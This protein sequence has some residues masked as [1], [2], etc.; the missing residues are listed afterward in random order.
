MLTP[1]EEGIHLLTL[2]RFGEAQIKG[3]RRT[4]VDREKVWA[5]ND[6]LRLKAQ[7]LGTRHPVHVIDYRMESQTRWKGP[8]L[9][10]AQASW[11]VDRLFGTQGISII[12]E[13]ER[14]QFSDYFTV[15]DP[16]V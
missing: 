6:R 12:V 11:T 13:E 7:A 8:D 9:V 15:L 4:N 16:G 1:K 10:I 2:L 5:L 14:E 3:W